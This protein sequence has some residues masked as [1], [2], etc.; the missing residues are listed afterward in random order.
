ME[1]TIKIDDRDVKFNL[2]LSWAFCYKA[3]FGIDPLT[4][5]IPAVKTILEI[6]AK[7]S[8]I[9]EMDLKTIQQKQKEG[10]IDQFDIDDLFE[11]MDEF[12]ATEILQL[13]W[14]FAKNADN[15]IPQPQEWF[16]DF[17]VF[18]LDEVFSTLLP[19]ILQ[20]IISTKKYKALMGA[21]RAETP[22]KPQQKPYQREE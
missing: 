21:V 8:N 16:R 20:S 17:K 11:P 4:V 6:L 15:E 22:K 13:I 12:E 7:I 2:S 1:C 5:L 10:E 3:Q 9:D 19:S 18:P 14:A